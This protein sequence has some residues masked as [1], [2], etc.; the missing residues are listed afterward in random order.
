MDELVR[1]GV[2]WVWMG[3]EG[4]NSQFQKLQ[5]VDTHA[6]VRELQSHGIRVL[7]STIIGLDSHTP[8][9]I[10]EVIEYAVT[11]NT[12]FHQFML[13]TPIPGTPLHA[14]LTAEG[15]MYDPAAYDEAD[16]HG[17]SMFNYQ[18]PHIPPGMEGELLTRAFRTDYE[19]NGPSV[20]RSVHTLLTGWQRYKDHPDPRVRARFAREVRSL[21]TTFTAA[22]AGAERYSRG[23]P[24][25]EGLAQLLADL[26]TEFGWKAKLC[27]SSIAGRYMAWQLGREE[28]RRARGWTLEPP[29]AYER[30]EAHQQE[31]PNEDIPVIPYVEVPEA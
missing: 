22:T 18:H 23:T 1:L 31:Y 9:N 12:D 28:R 11:H 30:N 14:R 4:E 17:Q 25:H 3:L 27:G 2:S 10:D 5:G 8:E 24:M 26:K 7:G 21:P 19:R 15:R 13:H 20:L 29:T 6:L 16:I